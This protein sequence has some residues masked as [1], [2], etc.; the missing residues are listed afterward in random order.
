MSNSIESTPDTSPP[1]EERPVRGRRRVLQGGLA[2]APVLMTLVSRPV[3]GQG[4]CTSP[5][6]YV[7]AN[8]SNA[9]HETCSGHP[10]DYWANP[11]HFSEWPSGF[12]PE[13]PH[14]SRFNDFFTPHLQGNPTLLAVLQGQ[15]GTGNRTTDNVARY[16]T[17]ALLNA[18][19][20]LTP[21]LGIPTVQHMWQEYVTTGFFSPFANAHWDTNELIDYLLTTM[22]Q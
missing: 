8:A 12:H 9:G 16:I 19:A 3:L 18:A 17:A 5:S 14:V 11:L 7:S 4:T 10:P 15:A 2:V 22:L 1:P 20:G 13:N 6:G 21:V